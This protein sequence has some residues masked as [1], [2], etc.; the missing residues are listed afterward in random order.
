M[1]ESDRICYQTEVKAMDELPELPFEQVL[2]YLNLKDRLKARTVSRAWRNT[3]DRYPVNTLCYS[4][5]P[6]DRILGKRR[7]VSGA[8]AK[9]FINSN[10]FASFFDTFG[11]T[12]LSNLKRLRLCDLDLTEED[13]KTLVHTV[14]SLGQLEQLDIIRAG[15]KQRDVLNLNLP[16][17]TNLQ[18]E[19]VKGIHNLTLEAPRLRDIKILDCSALKVEIV[20]EESV[21]RLLVDWLEYTDVENL[22][23]LQYLCVNYLPDIDSTFWSSLQKLKE[24]HT[25]DPDDD[26]SELFEQKQRSGS[27]DLKIYLG[28]LLLNG[29]DDPARNAFRGSSSGYLKG[30]WLV[31]LAENPS[32]LAD[33]IP[34]YRALRYSEIEGVTPD[35][36]VNLLKR[37]T[38]LKEVEVNCSVRDIERFLNFLKNFEKIVEVKFD[39]WH[40]QFGRLPEYC[41]VQK[42]TLYSSPSHLD[43]LRLKHLIYL[44]VYCS[45]DSETV[46]RAFEELPLSYFEFEYDHSQRVSIE[47]DQFKQ[48]E[49]WV[50][51]TLTTVPDLN[52]AIEC[53][54]GKKP[55]G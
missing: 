3:F 16:M 52:S 26:V 1:I 47:I 7:W 35:L 51:Y 5:R 14:N 46:R 2:S 34:F 12:I 17:L 43:F 37:F 31:C 19:D 40:Y 15:L 22:R 29:P 32:R 25:N 45:I 39:W 21:E 36:E 24:I 28:G 20:H 38:N 18:L 33:Q 42:L 13:R 50:D 23:N 55:S 41:A 30:E 53:I 44:N 49:V 11:Q 48:F 6:I 9:N 10:R 54:F 8:F 27:A 4:N